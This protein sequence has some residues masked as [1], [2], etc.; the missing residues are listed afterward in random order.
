[1]IQESSRREED[2]K[3]NLKTIK[4]WINNAGINGGRRALRD[5]PV[6]QVEMVVK[7]NLIGT[8]LCTKVAMDIM[9]EQV[10]WV[11][12]FSSVLLMID[13]LLTTKT[14]LM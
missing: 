9:A 7:V 4:Y 1:M 14:N 2:A 10:R 3:K 6:S 11:C 5:V 13:P 12:G 8:L